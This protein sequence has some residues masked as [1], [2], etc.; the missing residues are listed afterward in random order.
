MRQYV[1]A[2]TKNMQCRYHKTSVASYIKYM[3]K[4]SIRSYTLIKKITDPDLWPEAL[5]IDFT[6]LTELCLIA[7][8]GYIIACHK[9]I[10]TERN[11][12]VNSSSS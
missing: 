11:E 9:K 10:I 4:Q 1:N 5:F 12:M 8:Y 3:I 7:D 6:I 2:K